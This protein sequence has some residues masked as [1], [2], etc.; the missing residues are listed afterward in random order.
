VD[1][2]MAK[3]DSFRCD[4]PQCGKERTRDSNR[5]FVLTPF[6]Q[7]SLGADFPPALTVS[8]WDEDRAA[9]EDARH[10]CGEE[11]ALAMFQR[12]LQTKSLLPP[13]S[14]LLTKDSSPTREEGSDV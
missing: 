5:W 14:R 4:E 8:E 2:L 9:E 3:L 6:A 11:H 7:R 12:W 1:P 13:S 10:A